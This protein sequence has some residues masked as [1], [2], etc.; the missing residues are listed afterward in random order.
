MPQPCRGSICSNKKTQK[1]KGEGRQHAAP[2]GPHFIDIG[3]KVVRPE[4]S[5]EITPGAASG[6]PRIIVQPDKLFP[7]VEGFFGPLAPGRSWSRC[8]TGVATWWDCHRKDKNG[9]HGMGYYVYA[10][11]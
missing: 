11:V 6:A 7:I 1:T 3:V 2:I 8:R 4:T 5:I 9:K 10:C